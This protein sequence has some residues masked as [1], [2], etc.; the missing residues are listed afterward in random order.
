[1]LEQLTAATPGSL[2]EEK[3][4][5]LAWHYRMSDPEFGAMHARELTRRLE[6]SARTLPIDVVAGEKVIEIRASGI[7][8]G[9]IAN[10]LLSQSE[11]VTVLAMGDDRTDEDLFCALNGNGFTV[12]VGARPSRAT[13]R[14]ADYTAA[15]DLLASLLETKAVTNRQAG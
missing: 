7:N 3:T 9:V 6:K 1:M 4:T 11:P 15:R 2:I 10:R 12:H 5:G 8:K 13:Y 14:V